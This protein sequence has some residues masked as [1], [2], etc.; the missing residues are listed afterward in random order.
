VY[1]C[2]EKRLTNNVAVAVAVNNSTWNPNTTIP[3]LSPSE[4]NGIEAQPA[5]TPS[6]SCVPST[7]S[8]TERYHISTMRASKTFTV[9]KT[10]T[11]TITSALPT[12]TSTKVHVSQLTDLQNTTYY[13]NK[14]VLELQSIISSRITES[15]AN[16]TIDP[17]GTN[18]SSL[19]LADITVAGLPGSTIV[20]LN[21]T[22]PTYFVV[23]HITSSVIVWIAPAKTPD[24]VSHFSKLVNKLNA[25]LP[26]FEA[27]AIL[28]LVYEFGKFVYNRVQ[29]YR[30][31]DDGAQSVYSHAMRVVVRRLSTQQPMPDSPRHRS[32]LA[33][34]TRRSRRI[35]FVLSQGLL[36]M[37]FDV[38]QGHTPRSNTLHQP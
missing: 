27:L 34:S 19:P 13:M 20:L 26:Y 14:I 1:V 6:P 33:T 38:C 8:A 17:P 22:S 9:A 31:R 23:D 18:V 2:Q 12:Q 5:A 24:T 37:S 30:G 21:T 29:K 16:S 7:P 32:A 25:W 15:K 35:V 4:F 36:Y 28:T 3:A 10:V 11:V